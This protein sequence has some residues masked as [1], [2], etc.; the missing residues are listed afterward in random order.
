M[1]FKQEKNEGPTIPRDFLIQ[2]HEHDTKGTNPRQEAEK[3]LNSKL[4]LTSNRKAT[5]KTVIKACKTAERGE[6]NT[7]RKDESLITTLRLAAQDK[8]ED[9]R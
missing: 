3:F 7:V 8:L 6:D 5:L 9:S 2:S 1:S 4:T